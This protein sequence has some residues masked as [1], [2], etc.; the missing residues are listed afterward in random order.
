MT[1]GAV[2]VQVS[3]WVVAFGLAAAVLLGAALHTVL[4]GTE[5]PPVWSWGLGLACVL[6]FAFLLFLD[7]VRDLR[8]LWALLAVLAAIAASASVAAV[9]RRMRGRRPPK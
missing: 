1:N 5:Q 4:T 3:W 6:L 9:A 7:P 2:G 8:T